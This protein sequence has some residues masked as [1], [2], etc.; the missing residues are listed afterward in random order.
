MSSAPR[1]SGSTMQAGGENALPNNGAKQQLP[2]TRHTKSNDQ[3]VLLL[4]QK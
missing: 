3:L 4:G 1:H 2:D